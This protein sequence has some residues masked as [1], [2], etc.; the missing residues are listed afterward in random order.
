MSSKLPTKLLKGPLVDA[1]FEIRFEGAIPLSTILPG[2]LYSQWGGSSIERL[3]QADIPEQIRNNDP[4]LQYAPLIRLKFDKFFISISDRSL[5]VSCRYPYPGWALFEEK[6]L[7]TL[8][9]TNSINLVGPVVRY[10]LKYTDVLP[11][12]LMEYPSDYLNAKIAIGGRDIDIAK[13]NFQ[14]EIQEGEAINLLQIAG[15]VDAQILE[16]GEPKSGLL[17]DIDSIR[18]IDNTP[19]ADFIASAK[20]NL[21]SLHAINKKMFFDCLSEK[22]LAVLEPSFE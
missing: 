21:T 1:A 12:E 15:R 20:V 6:I 11:N 19:L 16:T 9:T 2:H 3:P 14:T 8:N 10:S 18:Q 22:G 5:Q 7:K 4:N 13:V 17:I